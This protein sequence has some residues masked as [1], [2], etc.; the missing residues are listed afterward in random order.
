MIYRRFGASLLMPMMTIARL[1]I[2]SSLP[3][4]AGFLFNS[5]AQQRT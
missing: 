1:D 3:K 4:M 5:E 2:G